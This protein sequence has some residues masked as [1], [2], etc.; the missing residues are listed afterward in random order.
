M[1]REQTLKN[2]LDFYIN[3]YNSIDEESEEAES[4][5]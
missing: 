5:E 4:E 2:M 1:A 3:V